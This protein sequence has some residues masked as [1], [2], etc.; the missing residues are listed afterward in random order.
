MGS[1]FAAK[2]VQADLPGLRHVIQ[3]FDQCE[4]F[5]DDPYIEKETRKGDS[6]WVLRPNPAGEL[7][8]SM[9]GYGVTPKGQQDRRWAPPKA[10]ETPKGTEAPI[11]DSASPYGHLRA[12]PNSSKART[13]AS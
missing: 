11:D 12:V 10:D 4:R 9:D 5:F 8:Q 3:L 7:R 6:V 1:W 13:K 2:W